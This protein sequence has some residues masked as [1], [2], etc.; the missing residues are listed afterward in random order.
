MAHIEQVLQ[1]LLRLALVPGLG[2]PLALARAMFK[3]GQP[4][5][6]GELVLLQ[7]L[8]SHNR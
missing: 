2:R 4:N 3:R 8:A 7:L 1:Y 6:E 5:E